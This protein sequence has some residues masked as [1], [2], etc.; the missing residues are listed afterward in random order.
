MPDNETELF[1]APEM[2]SSGH[3]VTRSNRQCRPSPQLSIRER[4][5]RL[6]VFS[7]KVAEMTLKADIGQHGRRSVGGQGACPPTF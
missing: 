2:T 5:T 7:D 4:K 6:R 3:A 1:I